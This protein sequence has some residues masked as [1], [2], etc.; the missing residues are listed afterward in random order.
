MLAIAPIVAVAQRQTDDATTQLQKLNRFY[1]YLHGMYVDSVAMAPIVESAI[2][3][4]LEEL[5]PHSAYLDAEEMKAAEETMQ[6]SFSGIGIEY[7]IHNDSIIVVNT[8]V[9]GPAEK[10]GLLPNDRIVEIDGENVV[11]ISRNDVPPKLRGERGS[12]VRIGVA[13]HG[14]KEILPFS[15]VRD[16]IPINSI[17]AVF[18]QGS[19]G[20]IK[21]NRFERN[22]MRTDIFSVR[23]S[24]KIC[25][26]D[27]NFSSGTRRMPIPLTVCLLTTTQ[28]MLCLRRKSLRNAEEILTVRMF[29]L[30]G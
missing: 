9:Q 7:N 14:I 10:V 18:K 6:G 16:N 21:V 8:V 13:R 20:Y 5:D 22:T 12:T 26:C 4:M 19:T 11:G 30:P 23:I 29:R 17:D 15:I 24:P 2:R 3:G 28:I 1:R 27:I 25:I